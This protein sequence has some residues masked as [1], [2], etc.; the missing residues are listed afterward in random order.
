MN[1]PTAIQQSN[2][3]DPKKLKT[4]LQ[5][6]FLP[7]RQASQLG[8]NIGLGYDAKNST[9][10]QKVF[11]QNGK[12]IVVYRGSKTLSDWITNPLALAGIDTQKEKNAQRLNKKLTAEYRTTPI[13]VGYSRGGYTAE[14]ASPYPSSSP[15]ITYN[16]LTSIPSIFKGRQYGQVDYRTNL[17][18]PSS[19]SKYQKGG[20][21]KNISGSYNPITSHRLSFL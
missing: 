4:L 15:V 10:E 7:Q 8:S 19:L 3:D 13:N 5:A 21:L 1:T 11:T 14:R 18:L 17:D 9:M 12:P 16:K 6:S 2:I 20:T